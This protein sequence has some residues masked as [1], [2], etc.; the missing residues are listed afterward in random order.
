[1]KLGVVVAHAFTLSTQ[2]AEERQCEASLVY[3]ESSRP[4]STT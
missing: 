4:V 1:M 2:E 3:T